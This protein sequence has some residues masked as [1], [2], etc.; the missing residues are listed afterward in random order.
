VN[1]PWYA[2]VKSV[3]KLYARHYNI[4]L[5]KNKRFII[6]IIIIII[7]DYRKGHLCKSYVQYTI[8]LLSA[9]FCP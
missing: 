7:I 6:I 3:L 2:H 4:D 9:R 8:G 1:S 5:R